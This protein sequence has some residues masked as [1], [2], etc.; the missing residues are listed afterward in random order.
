MKIKLLSSKDKDDKQLMDSK[1]NNLEIM[2]GNETD[3]MIKGMLRP[4]FYIDIN[5]LSD[6]K[7]KIMFF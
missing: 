6:M 4:I 2:I 7:W 1:S 5:T 3:E